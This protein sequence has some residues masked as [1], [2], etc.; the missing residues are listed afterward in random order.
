MIVYNKLFQ[1]ME[2]KG[3]QKT[4]LRQQGIHPRIFPKLERGELIRSDT[5][6]QLCKLLQCQP[7]DIMEYMEDLEDE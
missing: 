3:I 7:G 2:S 5:I 4:D 6:N 1:L